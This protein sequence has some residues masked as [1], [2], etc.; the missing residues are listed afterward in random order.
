MKYLLIRFRLPCG[1][2]LKAYGYIAEIRADW[3]VFS[4]TSKGSVCIHINEIIELIVK[5]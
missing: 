3:L 4:R 2:E 1:T 5:P